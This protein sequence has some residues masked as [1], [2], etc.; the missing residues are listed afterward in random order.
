MKEILGRKDFEAKVEKSSGLVVVKFYKNDCGPC[1]LI[2]PILEKWESEYEN[3]KFYGCEFRYRG[4]WNI[5][6]HY[7]IN[8]YPTILTFKN[9]C[10]INRNIGSKLNK[11]LILGLT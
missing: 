10:E 8:V 2:Q 5:N 11:D 7:K 6:M 1:E 4:N 3:I 9:G